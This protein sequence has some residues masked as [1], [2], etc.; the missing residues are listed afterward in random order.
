MA[1]GT[2]V[3]AVNANSG[4]DRNNIVSISD[5]AGVYGVNPLNRNYFFK[6]LP[7]GD[8]NARLVQRLAYLD[9]N[10]ETRDPNLRCM[11]LTELTQLA[12]NQVANNAQQTKENA[13]RDPQNCAKLNAMN[14]TYFDAGLFQTNTNG[15]YLFMSSRNNNFSNRQQK[16]VLTVSDAIFSSSPVV[17]TVL[18][19]ILSLFVVVIAL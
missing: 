12:R 10:L 17:F 9:Q 1:S 8:I 7:N 6:S 13:E 4:A 14:H 5:L 18:S 16:L 19:L 2:A 15:K 11:N 3:N